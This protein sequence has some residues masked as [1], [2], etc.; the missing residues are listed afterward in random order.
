MRK[1]SVF[2]ASTVIAALSAA[3]VPAGAGMG[4]RGRAV[5]RD[6]NKIFDRLDAAMA[7]AGGAE[8]LDVIVLFDGGPSSA[9]AA[10]AQQAVGGFRTRY[11]YRTLSGIAATM[12]S[13]QIEALAARPQTVQIQLDEPTT[14]AMDGARAA[15]GT[16]KAQA[17]FAVDGNNE[18][19]ACPGVRQYCRDDLV[20]A[21]VDTGIDKAHV[22]LDGG[23]VLKSVMCADPPCIDF[24]WFNG[25]HGTHT[26]SI[27]AGEGDAVPANRGIAPGAALL[28]VAVGGQGGGDQSGLDAGLE[29][30]L[31][32]KDAYGIDVLNASV[33]MK[34]PAD[35][36]DSTS[37]LVNRIA[38]A[39]I[40]PFISANNDGPAAG[41]VGSPAAAK[42]AVAVGAM[43]DPTNYDYT[44]PRGFDLAEFSGRGPTAD[45]RTKP[46][47][48]AA[49][50]GITA[51]T[52]GSYYNNYSTTSYATHSGTSM[53]SPFAAGIGALML[54]ANPGLASSGTACAVGDASVECL[55]GVVDATMSLPVKDLLTG[56]AVDWGPP[57]PD[58]EYGH[59]RV[60]G[61]AAIDAASALTGIGPEVPTHV[62]AEGSLSGTGATATHTIP[63]T[64]TRFPVAVTF[65]T[66]TAV[67]TTSGGVTTTTPNFDVALLDPSGVE[68]A[69]SFYKDRRQETVGFSPSVE[70][71]YTLR[72]RSVAG[73]GPYW[74]DAS[75]DGAPPDPTLTPPLPPGNVS[76]V[77]ASSTE[78]DVTWGD[79]QG[80]TRYAVQRSRDGVTGWT[81]VA[82][83]LPQD[84]TSYRDRGLAASSTYHY[85]VVASNAA[86]DSAPSATATATTT[87]D[88]SPPTTPLNLKATS[89]KA[90]VTLTWSASSDTGGSGLA[91]YAVYRS[92][93][94]TGV[95]TEIGRTTALSYG[96]TAVTKGKTYW[97]YV[98]AYDG[99]GNFSAASAK[100]SGKPT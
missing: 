84:T 58:N 30:V 92:T 52:A 79:V 12:T 100:V 47:I 32:N 34:A 95:F 89:G 41:T 25:D 74:F 20:A 17:D 50:V 63:V 70:G 45:G 76:A 35:G 2:L 99:A 81:Q 60:D 80:E 5:D 18:G 42:Y 56:T 96:D 69:V 78:I 51:A 54:D 86:G 33:A 67:Q 39:G 7:E 40:T 27:V 64:G 15:F 91:G 36:T 98:K 9:A 97:Y 4:G 68:V 44:V 90:K 24:H 65:V 53:S 46:D 6:A 43:A 14:F 88:T 28:S 11:E 1:T 94:S 48:S 21:M 73:S 55:D 72:V 19:G 10:A 8:S 16:D 31:A 75:F 59:G 22:D 66:P 38:A 57:G 13:A 71:N 82:G 23:K 77:A 93:S 3:T 87:P 49:G 26:A 61:Y 85:R 83:G 37:R 62:Y 29:W